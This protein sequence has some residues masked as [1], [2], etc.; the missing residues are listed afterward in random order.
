[1][2]PAASRRLMTSPSAVTYFFLVDAPT[3]ES[4]LRSIESTT[5][6]VPP[7]SGSVTT[8]ALTFAFPENETLS[9]PPVTTPVTG[10]RAEVLVVVV[11]DEVEVAT[12]VLALSVVVVTPTVAAVCAA[13]GTVQQSAAPTARA[14]VSGAEDNCDLRIMF[15]SFALECGRQDLGGGA[16]RHALRRRDRRRQRPQERRPVVVDLPAHEHGVVL[17]HRV[18]A[19]LHEHPAPI[20]ELHRDRHASARA[21][22]V[23]VLAAAF[24]RRDVAET[25]V[26][27]EDLAFLEVDVDGV[28]PAAAAVPE[29]P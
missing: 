23:D 10:T 28:I 9:A 2:S 29:G 21:Q 8:L 7:K 17:V 1:M 6:G 11:A 16:E 27:G 22:P 4:P 19:V 25:A 24:R 20:P 3:P 15:R 5:V 26:A 14:T 13:A 12:V 18:V